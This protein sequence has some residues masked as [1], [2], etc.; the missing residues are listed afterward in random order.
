MAPAKILFLGMKGC[1][2]SATTVENIK[3][4]MNGQIAVQNHL[5]RA[6][7]GARFRGCAIR[8]TPTSSRCWLD[9]SS[10]GAMRNTTRQDMQVLCLTLSIMSMRI[11]MAI[12]I[13]GHP[14][15]S[16]APLRMPSIIRMISHTSS[17]HSVPS[18]H[19][20][21]RCWSGAAPSSMLNLE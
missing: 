1:R 10:S 4:V 7:A 18:A 11:T 15:R 9:P 3:N 19:G 20:M 6:P 17:T 2:F 8:A 5:L 12:V 13:V 16:S 21:Q 14:M